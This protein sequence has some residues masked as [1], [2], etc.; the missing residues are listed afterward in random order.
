MLSDGELQRLTSACML[1]TTCKLLARLCPERFPE[2]LRLTSA[3]LT[4]LADSG[5]EAAGAAAKYGAEAVR[6]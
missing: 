1:G 5:A 4:V 3:L 2:N 6:R